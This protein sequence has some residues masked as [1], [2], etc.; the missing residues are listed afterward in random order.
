M[1]DYVRKARENWVEIVR[2]AEKGKRGLGEI[3]ELTAREEI[4]TL[5]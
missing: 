2:V 1:P 3:E 4:N 5:A